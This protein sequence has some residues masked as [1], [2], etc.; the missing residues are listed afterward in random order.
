MRE[1]HVSPLGAVLHLIPLT[2]WRQLGNQSAIHQKQSWDE[3]VAV[4]TMG[5]FPPPPPPLLA[6]YPPSSSRCFAPQPSQCH[7]CARPSCLPWQ[8]PAGSRRDLISCHIPQII[9]EHNQPDMVLG[10]Q[11]CFRVQAAPCSWLRGEG[12]LEEANFFLQ[13]KLA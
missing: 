5:S 4:H 3:S 2:T 7:H 8:A 1:G 10:H 9:N 6:P 11:L 13:E 12:G